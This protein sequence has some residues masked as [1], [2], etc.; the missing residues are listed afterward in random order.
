M[1][2]GFE[3]TPLSF[4]LMTNFGWERL[5]EEGA[6]LDGVCLEEVANLVKNPYTRASS[7]QDNVIGTDLAERFLLA[8]TE[9][10]LSDETRSE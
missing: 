1:H 7:R 3:W 9:S 6:I 10:N 8:V 2:I 4:G 5:L